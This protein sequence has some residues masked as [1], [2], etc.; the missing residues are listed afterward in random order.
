MTIHYAH[1]KSDSGPFV[2]IRLPE[3]IEQASHEIREWA[4]SISATYFDGLPMCIHNHDEDGSEINTT[5]P[6]EFQALVAGL[7][8]A[9][10]ALSTMKVTD[11]PNKNK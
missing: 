6:A 7:D 5:V 4:Q 9:G 10:I 11:S 3:S 8:G 2:F 1:I